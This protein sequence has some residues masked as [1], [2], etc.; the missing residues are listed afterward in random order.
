MIASSVKLPFR[1]DSVKLKKD[2]ECIA[3]AEWM[4]HFN[5]AIYEGE[6]SG[7]AL[8]SATRTPIHLYPD[9]NA[10]EFADTEIL[11]HCPYIQEVLDSFHCPMTSVRIL[12]LRAGAKIAEHRDYKLGYEDG[13]VRIHIPIQTA[14]GVEFFLD[15]I[16]VPM[17][18]GEA[19]YLNFNLPHR[20]NNGSSSNRLHLV[21]DC[22]VNDWLTAQL[23]AD[24]PKFAERKLARST[25]PLLAG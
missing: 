20:V 6:W 19:W 12:R 10:T 16:Q 9:P 11:G 14:K 2:A 22:K 15:G 23:Q 4:P 7:V 3:E 24:E 17:Q 1:F 25:T 21:M 8:R 5:Q 13:E 18:E